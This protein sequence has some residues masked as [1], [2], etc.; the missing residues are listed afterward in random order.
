[1]LAKMCSVS[2]F[3]VVAPLPPPTPHPQG[4]YFTLAL[5]QVIFEVLHV[6]RPTN[7]LISANPFQFPHVAKVSLGLLHR[8]LLLYWFPLMSFG[9]WHLHISK[10]LCKEVSKTVYNFPC[11]QFCAH[12]WLDFG[13]CTELC[14]NFR[15]HLINHMCFTGVVMSRSAKPRFKLC[16]HCLLGPLS[17]LNWNDKNTR[18]SNRVSFCVRVQ[19]WGTTGSSWSALR[20]RSWPSASMMSRCLTRGCTPVLFLPCPSKPPKPTWQSL[21]S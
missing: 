8:L 16:F 4:V 20:G 12:V 10:S 2:F 17:E 21:V 3:V 15:P 9:G 1:M 11:L 5:I 19:L 6:D 13:I 7:C 14:I 18:W